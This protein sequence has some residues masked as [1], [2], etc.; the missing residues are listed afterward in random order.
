[1]SMAIY[2]LFSMSFRQRTVITG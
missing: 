1:M 2:K